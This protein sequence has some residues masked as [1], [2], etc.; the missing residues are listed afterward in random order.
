MLLSLLILLGSSMI[1]SHS[2]VK[3]SL[4]RHFT[5]TLIFAIIASI[6]FM[7]WTTKKFRLADCQ[8]DWVEL[9]VDDAFWRFL[10]SIILLVI[11]YA[12]TPLMDDSD[13]EEIEEFLVSANL[14][15]GIKL[16]ATNS[17]SE[18]NGSAKPSGS[19]P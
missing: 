5:N 4:Y 6:V 1:Q 7:V 8:S 2:L 12:F 10:F 17:K 11:I 3:L 18:M 16:R 9:W 14:A 15:D 13:D 19:N